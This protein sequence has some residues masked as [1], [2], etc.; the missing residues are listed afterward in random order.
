MGYFDNFLQFLEFEKRYSPNT[1]LSYRTDLTQFYLFFNITDDKSEQ[2][3]IKNINY[4]DIKEWIYSLSENKMSNKSI[5]RKISTLKK[6][7][8][9][10][11]REEIISASPLTKILSPKQNK[12]LTKFVNQDQIDKLLDDELFS[13]SKNQHTDKII[14]S[15]LYGTGMRLSELINLK[16]NDIFINERKLKVIGKRNKERFIPLHEGLIEEIKEYIDYRKTLMPENDFLLLNIN[17]KKLYAKYVYRVVNK[18]LSIVTTIDKKSPHVLRHTFATHILNN[19]AELNA[20]KELL[21]HSNLS[22][23]QI[24]TH[25]TFEKIKNIY[26]QSH[27]RE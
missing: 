16:V 20:V 18:Y 3:V 27:P 13:N 21:G 6:Y 7:Y 25:N 1:I 14:I 23:T 4:K 24:Y 5:N 22:A 19:G 12:K 9:F 15:L 10:L 26:K 2:D 11:L 8:K 17:G